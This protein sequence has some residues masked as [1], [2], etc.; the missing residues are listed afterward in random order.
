[1][2]QNYF[3]L[4]RALCGE[5]RTG[6]ICGRCQENYT[7]HFHSPG[8]LCKPIEA[9]GCKVGWL[10]YILSELVP[11]T[12]VFIAVLVFNINFTSGAISSFIL[13]GQLLNTLDVYTSGL[14][15]FPE[16]VQ[17]NIRVWTHVYQAI[18]GFINLDYF[19]F[20]SISFCLLKDASA[21]DMLAF[22]YVTIL[23]TLLMIV[24]VILF[25]NKCAGRCCGR[26]C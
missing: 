21:L 9:G 1:M 13:F 5:T 4:N 8:F 11:V 7:V 10:L 18:Y 15:T 2:P 19:S 23:Y 20:E 24:V 14:I 12:M 16:T 22:K 25:M 3:E 26:Y 6:I 17:E